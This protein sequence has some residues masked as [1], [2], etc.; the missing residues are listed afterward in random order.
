VT[1]PGL[2]PSLDDWMAGTAANHPLRE[3]YDDAAA[4]DA[5][6]SPRRMILNA[7]DTIIGRLDA[8]Q[9]AR[10][11]AERKDFRN[12]RTTDD[13]RIVRS[14]LLAGGMLA[15]AGIGF[16]FGVRGG[17]PQPDLV[18]RDSVLGIEVKNR[19]LDGL[20][21]LERDL[22][23]AIAELAAPATVYLACDERPLVIKPDV[24][25]AIVSQATAM[26]QA[27]QH[28][29]F[30]TQLDQPWAATPQLDLSVRI[31]ERSPVEGSAHVIFEE[32]FFALPASLAD[33]EAEVIKVLNDAQKIQQARAMPT[34][35]LVDAGM[36]GMAVFRPPHIWAQRLGQLLPSDTPFVGIAVMM[37]ELTRADAP[38]A[39][40]TR[41]GV[42]PAT[43]T[44][45]Q[46]LSADL[47][48]G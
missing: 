5:A 4:D 14:E 24:R 10:L 7:L 40:A 32:G 9:P 13:L 37:P 30:V 29:T 15:R 45:V 36:T 16:D 43:L 21:E 19:T 28:G 26:I 17:M 27:G 34:I 41:P 25:A 31:T 38:I 3:W 33:A 12:A 23:A 47:G 1:G 2:F 48:L 46:K 20:R 35:L 6:T 39:L 11:S 18:L 42:E 44:A 22:D 8:A